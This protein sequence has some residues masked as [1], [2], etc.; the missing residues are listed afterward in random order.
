[1]LLIPFS[2]FSSGRK[3]YFIF[4]L[5]VRFCIEGIDLPTTVQRPLTFATK[6][7]V[8]IFRGTFISLFFLLP[9]HSF[10]KTAL[11]FSFETSKIDETSLAGIV[12]STN[13]LSEVSCSVLPCQIILKRPDIRKKYF[14]ERRTLRVSNWFE[15]P[16]KLL[17]KTSAKFHLDSED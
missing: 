11:H 16:A 13:V 4:Q 14:P 7:H 8:I 2:F 9:K 3:T 6:Y 1:M 5:P 17:R 12:Y 15:V 10:T